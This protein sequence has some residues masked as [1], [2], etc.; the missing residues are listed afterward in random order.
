MSEEFQQW[1]EESFGYRLSAGEQVELKTRVLRE[2]RFTREDVEALRKIVRENEPRDIADSLRSLADR[3][4]ALLPPET[5][6]GR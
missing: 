4:E 1:F 2:V 3:I 5:P 6:D